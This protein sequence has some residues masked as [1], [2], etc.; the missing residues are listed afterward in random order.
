MLDGQNYAKHFPKLHSKEFCTKVISKMSAE[1]SHETVFLWLL[2]SFFK[3]NPAEV[4]C[5]LQVYS[6][7]MGE[8]L[9]RSAWDLSLCNF[10]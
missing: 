3:T 10:T 1:K 9:C 5:A 6:Y 4:K 8:H 7:F 2:I